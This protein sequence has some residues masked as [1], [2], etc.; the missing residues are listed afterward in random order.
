MN[1]VTDTTKEDVMMDEGQ[2]LIQQEN[3]HTRPLGL[4]A[5]VSSFAQRTPTSRD[6]DDFEDIPLPQQDGCRK[7]FFFCKARPSV[8]TLIAAILCFALGVGVGCGLGLGAPYYSTTFTYLLHTIEGL[9]T[10]DAYGVPRD[11]PVVPLAQLINRTELDLRTGFVVAREP[12]VRAYE[13]NISHGLAAPDGVWKPMLLANGQSPGPLIEANVGDTI[14][15]MVRNLLPGGTSTSLHFHGLNQANSTWMDGAAGVSQCGIPGGGGTWTYEFA[16]RGQ[17]GTFWWHAH[18]AVQFT[19]GLYGPLVVHDPDERVPP[20]DAEQL[21]FL[22]ENHHRFAAEL[23][24]AYLAPSS[25]WSP[26]EAG[27]EPLSDNLLLNGQNTF[28]CAVESTTWPPPAAATNSSFR[29]NTPAC[30]GGQRYTTT[31]KPGATLRLRLIN[32]SAYLS[33]WFSIEGHDLAVVEVDG[34]EVEPLAAAGVHVNIGQRYSVLVRAT[35]PAGAYAIR[36]TLEREC[37]LPFSTYESSGLAVAGYEARGVLRYEGFEGFEGVVVGGA[38]PTS[39]E[40]TTTTRQE[41]DDDPPSNPN[42]WGCRDLPFD[43][44]VPMRPEAAYPLSPND[45]EH[46]LDF[47]FRQAGEVNRIFLNRT[48]WAPYRDDAL[49]WQALEQNFSQGPREQNEGGGS[50]HNWGFRLD[51]QVL[52]V[53]DRSQAVQVV[54]NSLDVM[55]HPFHMQ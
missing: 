47:Q 8:R 9:P 31:V 25:P 10:L 52:L 17:R 29:S 3:K 20:A 21:L 6:D 42:P 40:G 46:V 54:L 26:D 36:Q 49:L 48:S 34:V 32:H 4:R 50:Y 38:P 23:A 19:D 33:Y 45:P 35:R 1:N 11:L 39:P 28:D 16:V 27:V 22:G 14:R 18:A 43:Q 30:T 2:G 24:A 5:L 44:P 37:F 15:V 7:S 51:Q 12:A 41:E 55:E 13:F 53:P